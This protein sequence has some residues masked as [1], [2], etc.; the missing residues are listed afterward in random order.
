[1][2]CRPAYGGGLPSR[3]AESSAR[4]ATGSVSDMP[5]TVRHGLPRL[6][7]EILKVRYWD[8][9]VAPSVRQSRVRIGL[10]HAT[11]ICFSTATARY[12]SS[13]LT[14]REIP[15]ADIRLSFS[16][17]RRQWCELQMARMF[18]HSSPEAMVLSISRRDWLFPGK[19]VPPLILPKS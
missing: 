3:P 13:G 2:A 15:T 19:T 14:F 10:C 8:S 9:W 5:R 17:M 7:I 6:Y 11:A 18:S 16:A 4:P 1:M 12:G